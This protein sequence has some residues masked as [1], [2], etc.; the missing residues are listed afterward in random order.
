MKKASYPV[1]KHAEKYGNGNEWIDPYSLRTRKWRHSMA[2]PAAAIPVSAPSG[3]CVTGT[4]WGGSCA[5]PKAAGGFPLTSMESAFV[6]E[7][8]ISSVTE[9]LSG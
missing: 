8:E 1:F 9:Y 4:C 7:I 3:D 2:I 6:A 5:C